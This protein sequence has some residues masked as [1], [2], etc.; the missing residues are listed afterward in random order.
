MHVSLNP[1]L[2]PLIRTP[3]QGLLA[4]PPLWGQG[5]IAPLNLDPYITRHGLHAVQPPLPFSLVLWPI[6]TSSPLSQHLVGEDTG[7]C[8]DEH[9][10]EGTLT[11]NPPA[12][13][14]GTRARPVAHLTRAPLSAHFTGPCPPLDPQALFHQGYGTVL[15]SGT[16]FTYLPSLVFRAFAA[17]VEKHALSHG[18]FKVPG[19]DPTVSA[20]GPSP[21][22]KQVLGFPENDALVPQK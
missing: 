7:S 9:P 13:S 18:L 5:F 14:K 12:A 10:W 2:P 17:A 19:P 4:A 6:T 1:P 3:S 11:L 21:P 15:D 22:T 16:T 8:D 20:D